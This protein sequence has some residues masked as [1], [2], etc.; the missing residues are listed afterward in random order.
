MFNWGYALIG[1]S[2][3]WLG[4]MAS[5]ANRVRGAQNQ[6]YQSFLGLVMIG[7]LIFSVSFGIEWFFMGL[8][9][10]FIGAFVG[11]KMGK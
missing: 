3:G 4:G 9:E 5:A 6:G 11:V 10:L 8:I 2:I 7:F 1:F